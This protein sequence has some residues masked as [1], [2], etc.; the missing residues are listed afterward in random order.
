MRTVNTMLF[1]GVGVGARDS[2]RNLRPD[3]H[4]FGLTDALFR[5]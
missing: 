3:H 2:G 5:Y 1:F 4:L